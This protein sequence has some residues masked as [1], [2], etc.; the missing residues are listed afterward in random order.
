MWK[1]LGLICLWIL[2]SAFNAEPQCYRELKTTFFRSEI[3]AQAFSLYTVDQG[4][5]VLIINKLRDRTRDVPSRIQAEAQ[6][7]RPNPLDY[8]FQPKEADQLLMD[9]LLHIF[10]IALNE[11]NITDPRVIREMFEYIREQQLPRL[12]ECYGVPIKDLKRETTP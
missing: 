12:S 6:R 9:A 4:Q 10:T 7:M 3:V 2:A 11:S 5:W 1:N 8:P